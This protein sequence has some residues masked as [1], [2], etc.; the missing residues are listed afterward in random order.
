MVCA[1]CG[2]TVPEGAQACPSC[3]PSP[4][5]AARGWLT[6]ES[7][8]Q[9]GKRYA[10]AGE[11]TKIGRVPRQNQLVLDDPE[12]SR[13]HATILASPG[14]EFRLQDSSANGTFLNGQKID[15]AALRPG[16]RIR[17]GLNH[18]NTFLFDAP[19]PEKP[20][21][22]R[23]GTQLVQAVAA[24]RRQTVVAP[25]EEL[26][27]AGCR[28]Q[29][30]LDRYAV[31]D[32]PFPHDRLLLGR[33][34][35]EDRFAL[36]HSSISASHAEAT[37][38]ADGRA[39]LRDLDS[40]NGT[41]VNGER[42]QTRVL[43]EGDLVQLGA[44]D[45]YLL[46]FRASRPRTQKLSEIELSQPV[47]RLGRSPDN[48]I[49]LDHPTVSAFHAEIRRVNGNFEL[50]DL[51]SSNG[52]FVNGARIQRK[53]LEMR[54]RISFGA[55]HFVFNGQ[56][57]EQQADGTRVRLLASK[58]RV[59]VPDFKTGKP[60]RLLDD[61]SLA[62]DPCEFVGL[63]GPSGAGKST[64]MD[65]L[66]GFRPAGQGGVFLNDK[67]L[68]DHLSTLKLLIGYLPQDDILHRA[69]TVRE[70]FY[71]AARLR[72]PDDYGEAEI[73]TRVAE[74]IRSLDLAER[75]DNFIHQ[76]SGGQ[77]KRVSLGI[78][79]LS[80]PSL[81]FVD[82]PTAGQ[83]PRTEQKMM[84]LFREI[85]NKGSTV[86]INT[87]LLGSFSLLDKVAVLVR[88]KL[89]FFGPSQEMLPYFKSQRPHEVFD[90]LQEHSPEH[91]A[92]AYRQCALYKQYV[93]APLGQGT[94]EARKKIDTTPRESKARHSGW[95]QF[96][97]LL[98]R[99][100]TLKVKD[101]G[102][103]A[104]LL[105][106]PVAIAFLLVV[107][108]NGPNEPKSL[109][110]MV[111]VAL[112]FG[113]S[114]CVREIV[115]EGAIYKRER[116][117][118][119]QI[120]SYLGSKLAYLAGLAGVQSGLFLVVLT[121]WGKQEGHFLAAWGLMWLMGVQGGLI[122]LLISAV[123]STAEKA[124]YAFPLTM[125][126]QLLLAGML[127]PV[128]QLHPFYPVKTAEGAIHIEKMP[129][130][131]VPGGMD[132]VLRNG[133]SPLMV[134]RWGLESLSD[135]YIHDNEGYKYALLSQVAITFHPGDASAEQ[136]YLERLE[137]GE[138]NAVPPPASPATLQ[139]A[140]VLGIFAA[141]MCAAIAI[142]LVR[143][144]K[145]SHAG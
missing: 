51:R 10:I 17:F 84:E 60:L 41:F 78:E 80:K 3:R 11:T 106:P 54:D 38:D 105:L 119:L 59:E 91:W 28:F 139:Y 70:C 23:G 123:A 26:P 113:C 131:F 74:V 88:G 22:D 12:V 107:M 32:V 143:K 142:T 65:A 110:M 85:A 103:V 39:T 73:R 104:A 18:N 135:L 43:E 128:T 37:V 20:K 42:I 114:A 71:Y 58:L 93:A 96:L 81:L 50:V 27:A 52:T 67:S 94:P 9:K 108:A 122:G 87:H 48:T 95:R 130:G 24:V 118:D 109:F 129:D 92:N 98:G 14:G 136:Q 31:Q 126:P 82:E 35:G 69:L 125:I 19:Q 45:T 141:V 101:K 57:F 116:Q 66:N 61:I 112:W 134:A 40:T 44:C 140:G 34:S 137:R 47:I 145:I 62:L 6:A 33:T 8:P 121:L 15:E 138:M 53:V 100:L 30:V 76:L 68:Y 144:E 111:L 132:N 64:L 4:A 75:A 124:L 86:V 55:M 63:I 36:D 117:R 56:Q 72:L 16:D 2:A 29:L 102:N 49:R 79:L 1:N 89:A 13:F 90:R 97:T 77:R 83:D 127:I 99:Q 46:L 21:E 115:D 5:A 133:L 120:G 7:G 25:V